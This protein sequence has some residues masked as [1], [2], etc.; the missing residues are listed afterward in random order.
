[1]AIAIIIQEDRF[2]NKWTE[3]FKQLAPEIDFRVWPDFGKLEDIDFAVAWR[4][5]EGVL[6]SFPHLKAIHSIGAGVN[7]IVE[8]TSLPN[9]PILRVVDDRLTSDMAQYVS[10]AVLDHFLKSQRYRQA[11]K[12][13]LWKP[14]HPLTPQTTVGVL[15]LGEI[16]SY[17]AKV[18]QM[19]HLNVIGYSRSA[20]HDLPFKAYHGDDQLDTFLNHTDILICLL[21]LTQQ[22]KNI[23]N[24][25]LFY[26]L[27]K[28][29]YIIN[30]GR[31][32]HLVE[33]DLIKAI[34]DEQLS[35]AT[36]DVFRKEP[37]PS[38]H[39]FWQHNKIT[40]TPHV[41]SQTVPERVCQLILDNYQRLQ[42]GKPLLNEVDLDK[43]Y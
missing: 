40:I 37:L 35:G 42:T 3:V 32:T 1:M 22:T 30:V 39:P 29:A 4:P 5:P 9:V 17:T 7:Y 16:G 43:G 27:K 15:G 38:D 21:P 8:D 19:L 18:L 23:L 10:H 12:D 31:G 34:D 11:Q 25:D 20:K 13:N 24:K 14:S 28:G 2:R 26:K 36:L 33:E 41:A 6:A